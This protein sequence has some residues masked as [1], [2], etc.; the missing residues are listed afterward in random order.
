MLDSKRLFK[1]GLPWEHWGPRTSLKQYSNSGKGKSLR[2]RCHTP[3]VCSLTEL[4]VHEGPATDT[5]VTPLL[6]ASLSSPSLPTLFGTKLTGH[7][8]CGLAIRTY[9]DVLFLIETRKFVLEHS[10]AKWKASKLKKTSMNPNRK[11]T[12]H[13]IPNKDTQMQRRNYINWTMKTSL[14]K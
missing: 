1:S 10:T 13:S 14:E 5:S 8:G 6:P 12:M 7:G 11:T 2:D 3:S 9:P 4:P